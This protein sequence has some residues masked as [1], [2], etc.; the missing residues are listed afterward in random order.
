[1]EKQ[2]ADRIVNI[3]NW[4]RLIVLALFLVFVIIGLTNT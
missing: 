4:L 2:E 3:Y 1:M